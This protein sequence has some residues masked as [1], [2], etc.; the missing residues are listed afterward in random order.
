MMTYEFHCQF[1]F[2]FKHLNSDLVSLLCFSGISFQVVT[3]IKF[4]FLEIGLLVEVNI[5]LPAIGVKGE[6]HTG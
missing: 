6:D 5:V 1:N 2:Y 4:K 3:L